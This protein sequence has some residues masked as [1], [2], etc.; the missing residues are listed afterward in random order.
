MVKFFGITRSIIKDQK[1]FV[2][3]NKRY[4]HF[5]KPLTK[6]GISIQAFLCAKKGND[7]EFS[8]IHASSLPFPIIVIG[9]FLFPVAL[10][11]TSKESLSR[12][13]FSYL[14]LLQGL[15]QEKSLCILELIKEKTYFIH[16]LITTRI[17]LIEY[18][19]KP[20]K[21]NQQIKV[22]SINCPSFT[23]ITNK[24]YS[25]IRDEEIS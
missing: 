6:A 16:I 2:R 24:Q 15:Y 18:S 10:Q 5:I 19:I 1:H 13:F 21:R 4:K 9:M 22:I 3:T 20:F 25:N 11:Q 23:V 7:Q 17:I 8:I 12:I 14:K